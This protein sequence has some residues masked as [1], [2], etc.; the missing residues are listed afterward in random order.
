MHL[1]LIGYRGSGKSTIGRRL[2]ERLD[3]PIVDTDDLVEAESGM[4]IKD[5]FA[6]K[7]EPWFR[8]LEAR[9]VTAVSASATATIVSLGGGAVLR[10]S[11]QAILKSTGT[12]VWLSASAEYLFRRIQSDQATQWRRP[13]LSQNGG[14]SEVAEVLSIRTPIYEKL[15]DITVVVEGKTPDEICDEI[16]DCINSAIAE[17]QRI[18]RQGSSGG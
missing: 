13:N 12:C 8:D 14:F 3:R 6:T 5:I 7:G 15:S 11:S 18:S 16:V 1:Y 4:T 17:P 2:A 9:I 10:E